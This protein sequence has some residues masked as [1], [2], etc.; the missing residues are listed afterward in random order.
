VRG[1]VAVALCSLEQP[2]GAG[3]TSNQGVV[4]GLLCVSVVALLRRVWQGGLSWASGGKKRRKLH[5]LGLTRRFG[6]WDS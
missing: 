2:A 3:G 4:T 1:R 6:G 5:L